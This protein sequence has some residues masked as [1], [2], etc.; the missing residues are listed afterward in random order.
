MR[1]RLP[2]LIIVFA[3]K[4][5]PGKVKT[6]LGVRPDD[7]CALHTCFVRG[8]LQMLAAIP[9][10]AVELSTDAACAEWP[11]WP[12]RRSIQRPG[13]L[14]A[15]MYGAIER[16]LRAGHPQVLIL[17]SDSPGLPASHVTELLGSGADVTLGP[18]DDG[19]YYAICCRR[20][21]ASMFRGVRWSSRTTL[22]DTIREAQLCG[23][24][25]HLGPQWF[26][27]DT[28]DD[29]NR[30]RLT[31]GLDRETRELLKAIA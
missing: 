5:E 26:D 9:N 25:T 30:L 18:T 22:Q 23:L 2:P 4:P 16:S 3:R 27:I 6:R 14:G 19:G 13:D 20:A 28:P 7:A 24:N 8:T 1:H 11:E 12:G 15:R 17:G 29:L 10:V 21:H 31:P